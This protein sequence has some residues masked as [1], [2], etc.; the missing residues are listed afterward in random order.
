VPIAL[1]AM[2]AWRFESAQ[3]DGAK[4]PSIAA[5]EFHFKTAGGPP[6]AYQNPVDGRTYVSPGGW[7]TYL[8]Q[9]KVA[10]DS[11]AKVRLA[12]VRLLNPQS[13][14]AELGVDVL[15]NY[16]KRVVSHAEASFAGGKGGTIL[17]QFTCGARGQSV[18]LASKGEVDKA[19]LQKFYEQL[20][21]MEKLEVKGRDLAFQVEIQIGP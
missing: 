20:A 16:I 14:F 5:Q 2:A 21:A 19:L 11:T 3:L 9:G 6:E 7:K 15:S 18:K 1:K 10:P 4:V 12:S 17:A 8:P 13:D